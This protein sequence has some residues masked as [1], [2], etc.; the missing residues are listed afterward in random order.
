MSE[1]FSRVCGVITKT[2]HAPDD[3]K[4]DIYNQLEI[5]GTTSRGQEGAYLAYMQMLTSVENRLRLKD[6]S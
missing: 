6:L 3:K 5:Y 1:I 2:E 4:A